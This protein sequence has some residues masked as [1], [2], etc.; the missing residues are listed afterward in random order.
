MQVPFS[1]PDLSEQEIEQVVQVLR[2]GWITTGPRTAA[3]EKKISEYC[4]TTHTVCMNSAT[5]AMEMTLRLLGIGPGDEVIT[6]AYTF[7]ATAAVIEHV[8]AKIVLADTAPDSFRMDPAQLRE[9][10]TPRTKAVIPVDVGGVMC[11][12]DRIA[13]AVREKQH[14][15]VPGENRYQRAFGRPVIIADA[16]HSFGAVRN[17]VRSGAAA[18]FTCFSFHA[19]K[20]LT[21]ADG[22]AVTWISHDEINNTALYRDYKL[23]SLHGQNRDPVFRDRTDMW[24]YDV[25]MTGYKCNMTDI[26]AAIGLAQMERYDGMLARRKEIV[27]QYACAFL[28]LGIRRLEHFG[29][30]QEGNAHLYMVRIPWIGEEERNRIIREMS[31]RG[32]RCNVHFKPLPMLTAYRRMGFRTEDYP[33]AFRQYRNEITLPL[34]SQLRQEQADYVTGQFTEILAKVRP[35]EREE[36]FGTGSSKVG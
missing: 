25:T 5:S 20:N 34:Y 22:G 11:D 9:K 23:I 29:E 30:D 28:P 27:R 18:D 15:F 26:A 13:E 7:T 10:I 24:E 6:S 4:G 2:S 33:N 16:A 14:L 12:Y 35:N 8:G 19:V 32:I 21:T 3:F 31:E 17:G 1:S 36:I